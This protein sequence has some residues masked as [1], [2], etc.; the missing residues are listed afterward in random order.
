MV[1]AVLDSPYTSVYS[2]ETSTNELHRKFTEKLNEKLNRRIKR[3]PKNSK[4][5]KGNLA[6]FNSITNKRANELNKRKMTFLSC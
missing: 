5:S 3:T 4:T 6:S 1:F 2:E